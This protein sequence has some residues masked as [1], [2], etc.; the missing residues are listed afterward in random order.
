[1][2]EIY[3]HGGE[4][5]SWRDNHKIRYRSP[6]SLKK[7]IVCDKCDKHQISWETENCRKEIE[8]RG[9]QRKDGDVKNSAADQCQ[10]SAGRWRS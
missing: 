6:V 1:M 4:P 8:R 10:L 7:R 2:R 9:E 3:E 5:T